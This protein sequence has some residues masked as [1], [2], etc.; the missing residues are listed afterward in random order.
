MAVI[1]ATVEITTQ[2]ATTLTN[3][4]DVRNAKIALMKYHMR[5]AATLDPQRAP[6]HTQKPAS[7][8]PT[9]LVTSS[10]EE[11]EQAADSSSGRSPSSHK[12]PALKRKA[13][14]AS[15]KDD[16]SDAEDAQEP[17][18]K[19]AGPKTKKACHQAKGSEFLAIFDKNTIAGVNGTSR[20]AGIQ[21]QFNIIP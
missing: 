3:A 16:Q 20:K 18:H 15:A 12:K 7:P 1:G 19:D 14:A 6:N 5:P 2:P 9:I 4:Q 17:T 11:E 8:E 10:E 21:C 13:A